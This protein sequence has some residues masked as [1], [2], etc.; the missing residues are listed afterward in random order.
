MLVSGEDTF[1]P[2]TPCHPRTPSRPPG[3]GQDY[4]DDPG[5]DLFHNATLRSMFHAMWA[6]VADHYST[7]DRIAAFEI[8]SEVARSSQNAT[9]AS[10]SRSVI[11]SAPGGV[12]EQQ[13]AAAAAAPPSSRRRNRSHPPYPPRGCRVRA[14]LARVDLERPLFSSSSRSFSLSP[15]SHLL[16]PLLL[17]C[18]LPLLC[19]FLRLP[20]SEP[21]DKGVSADDV[22][23]FY[24]DS[25][26]AVQAADASGTPCLVG[27]G[28]YYKLWTFTS[29]V[30]IADNP[31]VRSSLPSSFIQSVIAAIVG[32]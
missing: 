3:A 20:F 30:V 4:Q 15:F 6:R 9:P 25:C 10:T 31:N 23:E 7:W 11:G 5:A 16:P 13:Q 19:P 22:R 32:M 26:A 17:L 29:D 1:R 28:S 27:S 12:T 14:G 2:F 8:L 21:R 24:A 18:P